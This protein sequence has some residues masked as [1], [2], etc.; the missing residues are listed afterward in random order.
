MDPLHVLRSWS[1]EIN[2]QSQVS[3]P[4]PLARTSNVRWDVR[5]RFHLFIGSRLLKEGKTGEMTILSLDLSL[6]GRD[7]VHIPQK[8]AH[9]HKILFV[10]LPTRLRQ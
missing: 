4:S 10:R 3:Q 9:N 8:M 7:H 2:T 5:P 6:L 1:T